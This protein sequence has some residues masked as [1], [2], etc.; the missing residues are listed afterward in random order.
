MNQPYSKETIEDKIREIQELENKYEEYLGSTNKDED[1]LVSD[2]KQ[3]KDEAIST[4][5]IHIDKRKQ[6]AVVIMTTL[7]LNELSQIKKFI[8]IFDGKKEELHDFV[9]NLKLVHS[10]IEAGKRQS[11]FSF[12]FESRLTLRVQNRV[13]QV[14]VPTT[15]E[16]LITTL[17]TSY[18]P[19]KTANSVLNELTRI[20]QKNN[21]L[22][23]FAERIESL[24]TELNEI[25]IAEAGETHRSSIT[26]TNNNIAFNSFINGLTDPQILAAI[27]A[28]R[29]QTFS[30]ALEI[31]ERIDSR[32]RQGRVMYQTARG[33]RDRGTE[34]AQCGRTHGDRCPAQGQ[35]CNKCGRH[36]H[37]A[38]KCYSRDGNTRNSNKNHNNNG[39]RNNNRNDNNSD[40]GNNSR[41]SNNNNN[42][43]NGNRSRDY[44]GNRNSQNINHVRDQ[45]NYQDPETNR[46]GTPENN[47]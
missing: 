18:K 30:Q 4:L 31:A 12:I 16:G 8:P 29:V 46:S 17:T 35:I 41:N 44:R 23:G 10:T 34:C 25:Q 6:K 33:S 43:N 15:V 22:T 36:N 38:N 1:D 9:A 26:T 24:V 11:F 40:R 2:F 42:R 19:I 32:G 14:S 5:K 13:K 3:L 20:V 39:N 47:H 7:D 37:F 45:E 28:S 27:D 21:N